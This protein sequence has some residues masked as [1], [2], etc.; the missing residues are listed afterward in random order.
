MHR[1][2]GCAAMYKLISNP[3]KEHVQSIDMFLHKTHS[4]S[5]L[6]PEVDYPKFSRFSSVPSGALKTIS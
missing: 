2:C 5:I 4:W 6:G 1:M 3:K